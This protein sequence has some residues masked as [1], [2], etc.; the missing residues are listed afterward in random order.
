MLQGW[1]IVCLQFD[2]WIVKPT[3]TISEN[4]IQKRFPNPGTWAG[5]NWFCP[6]HAKSLR[7]SISQY[8]GISGNTAEANRWCLHSFRTA[9]ADAVR[10]VKFHPQTFRNPMVFGKFFASVRYHWT[11]LYPSNAAISN[12][13]ALSAC[14]LAA[15]RTIEKQLFLS[16][17]VTRQAVP[18]LP[19]MV[20]AS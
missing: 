5:S 15:L 9:G 2:T 14:F 12:S 6:Q 20:S 13:F 18:L 17:R 11:C 8:P 3:A 19:S 4:S 1:S 7:R 16:I 10:D